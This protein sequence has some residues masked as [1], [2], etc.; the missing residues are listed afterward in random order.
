MPAPTTTTS[1]SR[2]R[3]SAGYRGIAAES[4]Q[5]D[6]VSTPSFIAEP[7]SP[8]SEATLSPSAFARCATARQAAFAVRATARQMFA[9][10]MRSR[11]SCGVM[12]RL[13]RGVSLWLD[14]YDGPRFRASPLRGRHESDIV[15]IGGG[16]TGCV[17]AARLAAR[18]LRVVVLEA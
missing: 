1:T 15:I 18:G 16:I 2:P 4:V 9:S 17:A 11:K 7:P 5:Y 8:H 6:V 13:R 12:A 14:Q 3:S 10:R